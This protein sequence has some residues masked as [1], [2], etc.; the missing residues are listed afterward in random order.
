[1]ILGGEVD[2]IYDY[3][4]STEQLPEIANDDD[5]QGMRRPK[6]APKLESVVDHYVELKTTKMQRSDRDRTS[7]ERFKLLKFWAQSFLL[8]IPRIIVGFRDD[9]GRL[10]LEEELETLKIPGIVRAGSG[11][12]DGN[13]C[14]N[15][16]GEV[17]HFIKSTLLRGPSDG[18]WRVKY[19]SGAPS[20][21]L[22]LVEAEGHGKILTQAYLQHKGA[23]S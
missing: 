4:P 8:G 6:A 17:L 19:R 23:H 3:K 16:A 14:L 9:E 2:C 11:S 1:M 13:V 22:F 15:F 7:F 18:V 5:L 10:H 12:W 21:E 20:V